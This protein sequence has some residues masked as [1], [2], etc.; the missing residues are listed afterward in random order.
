M[1]KHRFKEKAKIPAKNFA[2]GCPCQNLART[3]LGKLGI[4]MLRFE[5]KC[6]P[7]LF[8]QKWKL[9]YNKKI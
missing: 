1:R 2:E 4:P 6:A 7:I 8:C 9:W 3:V 5:V